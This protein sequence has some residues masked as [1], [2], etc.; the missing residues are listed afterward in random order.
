MK[1]RVLCVGC[2]CC[3]YRFCSALRLLPPFEAANDCQVDVIAV[4]TGKALTLGETGDVDVVLVHARLREDAFVDA[5]FGVNRRDVMANDFVL[6]GAPQDT[7]VVKGMIDTVQALEKIAL[8]EAIFVSRGDQSGTYTREKQ[9]WMTAG[10]KPMWDWS[11]EVGRGM[12]EVLTMANERQGYTL[13]DRGTS[14]AYQEK[15][16][17]EIVVEGDERLFNP[18]G[19]IAVNPTRHPHVQF[20]LTMKFINYL[21]SP[22][23]Q[24][25]INAYKIASQQL[26]FTTGKESQK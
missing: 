3:C 9:L 5:G 21:V 6:V 25:R 12:G 24:Q 26:F 8:N 16:D 18:Y 15:V 22:D 20:D 23:A 2:F 7:A 11:L 1:R 4:G 14:I 17:L 10:L 13:T 19:V